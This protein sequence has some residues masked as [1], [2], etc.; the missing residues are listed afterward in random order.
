MQLTRSLVG[1]RLCVALL[2]LI[3]AAPLAARDVSG[4]FNAT[5]A[6]KDRSPAERSRASAAALTQVLIKL[7][8]NRRIASDGRASALQGRASTLLLQYAYDN[9]PDGSLT[10]NAH[11]DEQVLS[12][13]LEERGI[14]AWS[15]Q[16]PDTVVFVIADD[17]QGRQLVGGDAPGKLGE[18]LKRKAD[19]RALP[20]LL[21][22]L[23]I[24]E[25]SQLNVA[26]DWQTLSNSA[27]A[28][29]TRYAAAAVLVGYLHQGEGQTW[30]VRWRLDVDGETSEW[31]QQ[32]VQDDAS[33]EEGIDAL[34]D[35][36]AQRY[37]AQDVVPTNEALSLSVVGVN[38]A[39]DYARLSNY[40]GSLDTLS[41]LFLKRVDNQRVVFEATA[42][43]GRAALTQS[44]GFGRVLAPLANQADTYELLP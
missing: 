15:K 41:Q 28:L 4:L 10:L 1:A 7:T 14:V 42:R 5:V 31:T 26:H 16:R 21:P 38:S 30:D 34:G 33:M 13:E 37:A 11:F 12:R 22:L 36:L 43:G 32:A 23:D 44:I 2:L 18:V 40:L 27:V 39:V 6:I 35:A 29:A 17:A 8:G 9:A 20:L 25:T 24:E 19:A 3:G